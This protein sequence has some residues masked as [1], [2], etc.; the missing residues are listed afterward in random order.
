M[1]ILYL[2]YPIPR[3]AMRKLFQEERKRAAPTGSAF[4]FIRIEV[5]CTNPQCGKKLKVPLIE[6]VAN[7]TVTCGVCGTVI[8]LTT[9]RWRARLAQ[10]SE[11]YKKIKPPRNA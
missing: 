7:D 8:D 2:T 6:L 10:E 4:D 11:N 1:E 5:D 3:S 9:E